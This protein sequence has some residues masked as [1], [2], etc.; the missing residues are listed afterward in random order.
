[1]NIIIQILVGFL[2]ADILT[3]VFH[4]FEDTYLDYCINVPILS[5]I[6]KDNE[7]H[8]YFPRA[9]IA[10]SY[11]D[12]VSMS[13]PLALLMFSILYIFCKKHI[14]KYPY[15]YITLF[16]FS[17]IANIV[18]RFSHLREC[19]TSIIL[20]FLQKIGIFC[21]HE[22]HKL[23]HQLSNEKYCVISGYSN[24]VLDNIY[25]WRFLENTIFM[26]F[27]V[28]PSRKMGYN[29]YVEIHNYM[30]KNN[31]LECPDTPNLNDVKILKEN[32]KEFKKCINI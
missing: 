30:H 9:M 22:Q 7:L 6:S 18:H 14:Y 32:L 16:G 10:Y 1:M 28:S 12:H 27:G 4:W 21:S 31:K 29:D 8:H 5:D 13:L 2:L 25:F 23:H 15:L 11:Y 26:I 3:G 20:K 17:I 24:Y 19:E